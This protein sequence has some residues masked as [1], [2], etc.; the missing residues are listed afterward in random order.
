[1]VLHWLPRDAGGP[2]QDD[3]PGVEALLAEIKRRRSA[4]NILLVAHGEPTP[5]AVGRYLAEQ[6]SNAPVI[7]DWDGALKGRWGVIYLPTLVLLDAEGRVAGVYGSD[8]V[9]NPAA[10]LDAFEAGEPLPSPS[11]PAPA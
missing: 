1:V 2:P 11:N 8:A 7:F 4:L 5:G 3:A 10:L 6:G 9:A